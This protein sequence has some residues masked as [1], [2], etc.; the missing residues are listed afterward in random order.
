MKRVKALFFIIPIAAV[1][2][3]ACQKVVDINLNA[4]APRL[5]IEG[6]LSDQLNSCTVNL[7]K[8]VNYNESN[9][10]PAV[11]GAIVIISDNLGNTTTLSEINPGLYA[12]P[13]FAGVPGRIY[14]LSVTTEGQ[15]YEAVSAMPEPVA[16]DT[17]V[18]D[19]IQ[20]GS[21]GFGSFTTRIFVDV[22]YRDPAGIVNFYRFVEIVNHKPTNS[23]MVSSDELRDGALLFRRMVRFDTTLVKGDSVTVELRTIDKAVFDYLEQLNE[24]I[25]GGFGNSSATPANPVSN[26]TNGALGYFSAYAVKSKRLVVQ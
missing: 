8:S 24:D 23:I 25:G 7:S 6:G 18:Q 5:I 16:I 17:M 14:T 2:F 22:L 20:G 10:F 19:S 3:T 12:D 4:S 1:L 9:N 26:L 21:F 11:S 15:T 13:L